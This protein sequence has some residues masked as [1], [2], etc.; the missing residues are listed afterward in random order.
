LEEGPGVQSQ[1]LDSPRPAPW[2]GVAI[3]LASRDQTR[4]EVYGEYSAEQD[5]VHDNNNSQPH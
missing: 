5:D 4:G 3:C 2:L 1:V